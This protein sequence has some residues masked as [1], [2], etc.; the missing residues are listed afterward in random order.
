MF[1]LFDYFWDGFK[2]CC[3]VIDS[4]QNKQVAKRLGYAITDYLTDIG[5]EKRNYYVLT[6]LR[7]T[8]SCIKHDLMLSRVSSM[9]AN[10]GEDECRYLLEH[11]QDIPKRL[12]RFE[13]AFTGWR[14]PHECRDVSHIYWHLPL[15]EDT[16]RW[17]QNWYSF[18]N[19]WDN[20]TRV[21]R[22]MYK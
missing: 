4:W 2:N 22:R 6:F 10:L 15:M 8:E 3:Q 9:G 14:S 1:R 5:P 18:Y 21:L 17:V 13:M 12:R 11:Q 16:L 19:G 7:G 20:R